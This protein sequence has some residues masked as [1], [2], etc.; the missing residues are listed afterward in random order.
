[1]IWPFS[2]SPQPSYQIWN[3]L[4]GQN[5]DNSGW[6]WMEPL[7]FVRTSLDLGQVLLIAMRALYLNDRL[8]IISQELQ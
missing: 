1:M 8:A 5:D 4:H 6:H 7:I 2:Y 3:D